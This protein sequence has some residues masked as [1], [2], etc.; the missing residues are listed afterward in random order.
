MCSIIK[1]KPFLFNQEE[2]RK[3]KREKK[4]KK[5]MTIGNVN[6]EKKKKEGHSPS[7]S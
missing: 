4:A 5:V 3:V 7:Q 1:W 2:H 6:E